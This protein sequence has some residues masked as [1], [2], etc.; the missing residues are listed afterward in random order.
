MARADAL[1]RLASRLIARHDALRQTLNYE[2]SCFRTASEFGGV[3]DVVDAAVDS[4]NSEIGSRLVEI[5][6]RELSRIEHALER[7][8]AGVYGRCEFC[9]GR[10]SASRLNALPYACSCI[11]CQRE[12]EMHGHSTTT[13]AGRELWERVDDG[14]IEE[15]ESDA[16]I[17]L[18][19]FEMEFRDFGRRSVESLLV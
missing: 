16:T 8:T 4:A 1:L 14:P 11:D 5:E 7:I 19:D 13:Q 12:I 18:G 3:G 10:I 6:S 2:V 15:G 17:N 9:R